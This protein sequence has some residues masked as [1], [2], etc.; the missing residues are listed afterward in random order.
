MAAFNATQVGRYFRFH[1]SSFGSLGMFRTM[2]PLVVMV[3][4]FALVAWD[5][6]HNGG[7][8]LSTIESWAKDFLEQIGL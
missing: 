1:K 7:S 6:T 3:A 2:R 5:L 4:I 8:G